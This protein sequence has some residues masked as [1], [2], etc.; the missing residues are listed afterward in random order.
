MVSED[1]T[2]TFVLTAASLLAVCFPL[3]RGLAIGMR[4]FLV[5]RRV[6]PGEID[7]RPQRVE[8]HDPSPGPV[9]PPSDAADERVEPVGGH[10]GELVLRLALPPPPAERVR[11]PP[12]HVVRMPVV[13]PVYP[14]VVL[15]KLDRQDAEDDGD[16]GAVPP[17]DRLRRPLPE[18]HRNG[19]LVDPRPLMGTDA[20]GQPDSQVLAGA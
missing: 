10:V 5:T 2:L 11:R 3:Y 9:H 16:G 12:R 1:L 6:P 13:G 8:V 18:D 15:L 19:S 14:R 17:A 7:L 4:A 20:H